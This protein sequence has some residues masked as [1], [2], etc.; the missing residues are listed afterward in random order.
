MRID[1]CH[2]ALCFVDDKLLSYRREDKYLYL[3]NYGIV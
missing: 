2:V 3:M 1:I